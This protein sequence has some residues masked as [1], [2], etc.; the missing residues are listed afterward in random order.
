MNN[1]NKAC[2]EVCQVLNKLEK[3]EYNKIPK[4]V[5]KVIQENSDPNY[6]FKLNE[7]LIISDQPFL[8]DTRHI[9]YY[10]YREYIASEEEKIEMRKNENK[11][12]QKIEQEKL[13]KYGLN[14]FENKRKK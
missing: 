4:D 10:L 12:M 8:D 9:I 6:D 2:T 14:I 1:F 7:D 3:K 13:K 11:E 5:L